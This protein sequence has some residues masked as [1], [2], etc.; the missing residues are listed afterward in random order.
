MCAYIAIIAL[1]LALTLWRVDSVAALICNGYGLES[2]LPE[3]LKTV[4]TR[5][6]GLVCECTG[7]VHSKIDSKDEMPLTTK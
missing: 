5:R 2:W 4:Y 1:I 6:E 7:S 3:H